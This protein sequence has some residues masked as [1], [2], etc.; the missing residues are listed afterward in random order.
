MRKITNLVTS[1][2]LFR[3]PHEKHK[4]LL[5]GCTTEGL[6]AQEITGTYTYK[7]PK[8][9]LLHT[10]IVELF[11][12]KTMV[13]I[14]RLCKR[15][16][17]AVK[18][19]YTSKD[20]RDR[21]K[22]L[23]NTR[24]Y[25]ISNKE[26]LLN[27]CH[28]SSFSSL[29]DR[30]KT[31]TKYML[32]LE[33]VLQQTS[34]IPE[35]IDN[36]TKD[37]IKSIHSTSKETFNDMGLVEFHEGKLKITLDNKI[38]NNPIDICVK[39]PLSI[40]QIDTLHLSDDIR[41]SVINAVDTGKLDLSNKYDLNLSIIVKIFELLPDLRELDFSR[42]WFSCAD[43]SLETLSF[44]PQLKILNLHHFSQIRHIVFD[45]LDNL[46]ELNLSDNQQLTQLP[47]LSATLERLDVSGC[48]ITSLP[49]N[50]RDQF[51][52]L[53]HL[54]LSDNQQL[55]QFPLLPTTLTKL[56]LSRLPRLDSQLFAAD[57]FNQFTNLQNLQ[58]GFNKQIKTFPQLPTTLEE[59]DMPKCDIALLPTD[60]RDQL[61]NLRKF[62]LTENTNL[63]QLPRLPITLEEVYLNKCNVQLFLPE[64]IAQQ[65]NLKIIELQG[66][67][68][69]DENL[70]AH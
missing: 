45:E 66:N 44:P 35:G 60:L 47:P 2:S 11:D 13:E 34:N 4:N 41:A 58:L 55:T 43:K 51:P 8:D 1:P 62:N 15:E 49:T 53:Q 52:K 19:I 21:I 57:L 69:K 64:F 25:Q 39:N 31:V 56:D 5:G 48:K 24:S 28:D 37:N 30:D 68:I 54:N 70:T 65:P 38:K 6:Q 20:T 67:K 17:K 14:Q 63:R 27:I 12:N 40:D 23:L 61:P 36:N 59:L 46:E 10:R 3:L 7:N 26:L 33:Q 9:K 50:L 18:I 42:S 29:Q 22:L 32:I 16:I